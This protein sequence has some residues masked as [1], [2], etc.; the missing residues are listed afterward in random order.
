[1]KVTATIAVMVCVLSWQAARDVAWGQAALAPV[2]VGKASDIPGV[3]KG[4]TAIERILTGFDGLDDPIGLADGTLVFSEPGARRI[5]RVN[6]E[7]PGV[8]ARRRFE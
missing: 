3:V 2:A 8:G 7:Q 1:M 6:T 5:H 4:G